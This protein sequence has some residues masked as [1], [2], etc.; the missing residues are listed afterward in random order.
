MQRQHRN[1]SRPCAPTKSQEAR[2]GAERRRWFAAASAAVERRQAS[3]PLGVFPARGKG[4][5]DQGARPHPTMRTEGIRVCRRFAFLIFREPGAIEMEPVPPPAAIRRDRARSF[6]LFV[7]QNS[8]AARREN[9][10]FFPPP[11]RA[12]GGPCEAW[13]RGR[14]DDG[15]SGNSEIT[16]KGPSRAGAR[17]P[18]PLRGAGWPRRENGILFASPRVRR[19][20]RRQLRRCRRRQCRRSGRPSHPRLSA[21]VA[22]VAARPSGASSTGI[23]RMNEHHR[24]LQPWRIL[25]TRMTPVIAKVTRLEPISGPSVIAIP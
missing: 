25:S 19:P 11:Q 21:D 10:L 4:K 2:A 7:E 12:G 16:L 5:R 15:N 24:N 13:W 20:V 14:T 23:R 6:S 1:P 3:A 8:G 17:S 9:A 22:A 18:S